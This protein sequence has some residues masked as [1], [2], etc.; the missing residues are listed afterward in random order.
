MGFYARRRKRERELTTGE[1]ER[2]DVQ[3]VEHQREGGSIGTKI[4]ILA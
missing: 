2:E 1:T 4:N 3:E